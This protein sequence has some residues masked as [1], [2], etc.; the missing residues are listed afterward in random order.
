MRT[1]PGNKE[2]KIYPISGADSVDLTFA[3]VAITDLTRRYLGDAI[4]EER[5]I[6]YLEPLSIFSCATS[7]ALAFEVLTMVRLATNKTENK[8]HGM[9][10]E[11]TLV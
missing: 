2:I 5:K 11:L 6:A 3:D 7:M 8:A 10:A 9:N 1:K 4:H